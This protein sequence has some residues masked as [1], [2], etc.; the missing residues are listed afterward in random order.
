LLRSCYKNSLLLAEKNKLHS[1]AFPSISTG[2]YH[3]PVRRASRIALTEIKHTLN[4][5]NYLNKVFIVLFDE[6]TFNIYNEEYK[7]IL[8]GS[9]SYE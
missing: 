4:N 8:Q 1:I 5:L 3:F 6:K 2:A 7:N 9:E